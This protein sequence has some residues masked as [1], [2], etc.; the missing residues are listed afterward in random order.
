MIRLSRLQAY[1]A[2][3][4]VPYIRI[5]PQ[6]RCHD[7]KHLQSQLAQVEAAGG[8]GLVLRKAQIP[9]QTGRSANALKVKS[10]DDAEGTVVGYRPGKGK[11]VG[12]TGSLWIEI[13]DGKRF[14]IGSGL[15]EQQRTSPPPTGSIITFKHHGYTA[16]G[17]P[18]FA[19]FLR[20]RHPV[21]KPLATQ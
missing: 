9:F 3:H 4:S 20:V 18:R 21:D 12:K 14:Y 7:D 15:S 8:E 16:N 13:A 17:I 11:Y 10:F 6:I 5:I 2:K 1:L 19:S